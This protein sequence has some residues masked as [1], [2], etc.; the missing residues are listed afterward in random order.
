RTAPETQS[1]SGISAEVCGLR[2]F[3]ILLSLVRSFNGKQWFFAVWIHGCLA[4][5]LS[6][7]SEASISAK[8]TRIYRR[9]GTYKESGEWCVAIDE[10]FDDQFVSPGGVCMFVPAS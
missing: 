6:F 9:E 2:A 8:G 10:V 1:R 7:A 3:G 5:A 4:S